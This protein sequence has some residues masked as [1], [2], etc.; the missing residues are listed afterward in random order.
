MVKLVPHASSV[1]Q[2][3]KFMTI[4]HITLLISEN[5]TSVL[6]LHQ[7]LTKCS[8]ITQIYEVLFAKWTRRNWCR[9]NCYI[10]TDNVIFV[11]GHFIL[12]LTE[13]PRG[14]LCNDSAVRSA[15]NTLLACFISHMYAGCGGDGSI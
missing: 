1:F 14:R 15:R 4:R 3:W 9:N 5:R 10:Y 6:M 8:T 11:L 12:A 7:I 13:K 2:R